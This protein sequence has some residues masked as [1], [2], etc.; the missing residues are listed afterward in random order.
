MPDGAQLV[1]AEIQP[2]ARDRRPCYRKAG[3][4]DR[5]TFLRNFDGD[6]HASAYEIEM[7]IAAHQAPRRDTEPV[8]GASAADLDAELVEQYVQRLRASGNRAFESVD[9]ET[10]LRRTKVL[11]Q[12]GDDWVPSVAGMLALGAY[13]QQFDYLERI[14]V[15]FVAYPHDSVGE[16]DEQGNRTLANVAAEGPIPQ[17]LTDIMNALR[18]NMD[19]RDRIIDGRKSKIW[20]L[21]LD[22]LREAVV[23]A[24]G[25]RDLSPTG[26]GSPVQVQLFPSRLVIRN[27]GGL[28]GEITEETLGQEGKTSSRNPT[29]MKILETTP[30][31][32]GFDVVAENRGTG[33]ATMNSALR[34]AGMSLPHFEDQVS[35]FAVTFPEHT[36]L[37]QEVLGWLQRI[38]AQSCNEAQQ[39]ALAAM[40]HGE[41]INNERYR[42]LTGI[43][44]SRVVTTQLSQLVADGFIT[45]NSDR[46]WASYELASRALPENLADGGNAPN[47]GLD[48]VDGVGV[49]GVEGVDGVQSAQRATDRGPRIATVERRRCVKSFIAQNGPV[50]VP[51]IA[52]ALHSSAPTIERDVAALRRKGE[53]RFEGRPASGGYV[54]VP[55]PE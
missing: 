47:R 36:L 48:G 5:G 21:P 29:L 15:E 22:A 43:N 9:T 32:D 2:V 11:V 10:A 17:I 26:S 24:M 13:P 45:K 52:A 12:N 39:M 37:S 30:A 23:N 40:Y 33:I 19:A 34:Q 49:E 38:G 55:G 41:E 25:H 3:G 6:R 42:A 14:R 28:F 7:M 54:V 46:R 44:D 1:V 20:D 35:S 51:R 8:P 27:P 53:I 31:P 18:R 4:R 16:V 50:R